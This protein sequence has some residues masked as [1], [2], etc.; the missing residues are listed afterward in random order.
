MDGREAER[1][2]GGGEGGTGM[3]LD[4]ITVFGLMGLGL[5]LVLWK[6]KIESLRA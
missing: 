5:G 6:E 4:F 1:S 2:G 3:V